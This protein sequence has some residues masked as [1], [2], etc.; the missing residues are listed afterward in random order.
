MPKLLV[1]YGTLKQFIILAR[2][3]TTFEML[4]DAEYLRGLHAKQRAHLCD[5]EYWSV[6]C[7]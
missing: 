7:Y 3:E 4:S 6:R 5:E 2:I 1:T